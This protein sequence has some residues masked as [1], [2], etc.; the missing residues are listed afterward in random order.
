MNMR[1]LA[2]FPLIF[3]LAFFLNLMWEY[4]HSVLYVHYQGGAITDSILLHAALFDAT[5]ITL[6]ALPSLFFS[7]LKWRL[8]LPTLVAFMFAIALEL[9]ALNTGRWAYTKAMPLLPFIHVGLTPSIQLTLLTFII[10]YIV[11]PKEKGL[12]A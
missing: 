8:V 2:R 3:L 4:A 12:I 5:F 1:H 10:L 7:R 11:L 6:I 9:Y